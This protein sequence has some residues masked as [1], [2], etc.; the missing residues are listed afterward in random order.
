MR[1]KEPSKE[2]DDL[3]YKVIGAA[4]EVHRTFGLGIFRKYLRRSFVL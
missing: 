3:A 4:M 2:L 1:R